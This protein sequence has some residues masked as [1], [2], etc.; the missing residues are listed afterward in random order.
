MIKS[1]SSN[2]ILVEENNLTIFLTMTEMNTHIEL[3]DLLLYVSNADI[4]IKNIVLS[5]IGTIV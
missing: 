2:A 1:N 4:E 3:E 5:Q